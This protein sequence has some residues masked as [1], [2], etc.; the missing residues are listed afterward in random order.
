MW[1]LTK[2][3]VFLFLLQMSNSGSTS[4]AMNGGCDGNGGW[5]VGGE[6]ME[7]V[8][9]V[10]PFARSI[11]RLCDYSRKHAQYTSVSI[12]QY[13]RGS[14]YTECPVSSELNQCWRARQLVNWRLEVE[15]SLSLSLFLCLSV[16][17]SVCLSV[18]L[19]VSLSCVCVC[20]CVCARAR[21]CVIRDRHTDRQKQRQRQTDRQR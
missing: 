1:Y 14:Y 7:G 10:N 20:V 6:M 17:A 3:K 11:H 9:K 2:R 4:N 16:S 18:C 19:S 5:G 12:V 8:T 13:T 21:A 15:F